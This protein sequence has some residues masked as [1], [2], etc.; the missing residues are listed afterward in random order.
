[1]LVAHKFVV[2]MK[3]FLRYRNR[4]S[5]NSSLE[6][7]FIDLHH[8][9]SLQPQHKQSDK[10]RVADVHSQTEP[11][12]VGSRSSISRTLGIELMASDEQKQ[13]QR[14]VFSPFVRQDIF[15]TGSISTL[16]EYK[17]SPDMATYIQV[18]IQHYLHSTL[19]I[20][21]RIR[22]IVYSFT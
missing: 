3:W 13:L 2:F 8:V 15:Y 21:D 6:N 5:V 17:T 22:L 1:M 12:S 14:Q 7:R 16:Q 18:I 10:F 9:V 20:V 4:Y 19:L 11:S